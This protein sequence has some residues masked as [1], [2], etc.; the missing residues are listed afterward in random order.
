MWIGEENKLG[1]V[2]KTYTEA[3]LLNHFWC[4]NEKSITC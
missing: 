2:R 4:R 1:K 3:P